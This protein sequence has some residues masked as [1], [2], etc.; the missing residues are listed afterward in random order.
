MIPRRYLTKW[1]AREGR[2]GNHSSVARRRKYLRGFA[3]RKAS[4]SSSVLGFFVLTRTV[5]SCWYECILV[6]KVKHG[7]VNDVEHG[8]TPFHRRDPKLGEERT[9]PHRIGLYSRFQ[10]GGQC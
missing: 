10:K 2:G 6:S 8:S 3:T 5:C 1:S 4:G 7:S 9:L